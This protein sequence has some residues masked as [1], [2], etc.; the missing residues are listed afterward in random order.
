M[1]PEGSERHLPTP[2]SGAG[3]RVAVLVARFNSSI[4]EEL[5]AGC[6]EGLIE[7]G[8]GQADIHVGY[9]PGAWELPQAAR[10]AAAAA[11]FDVIVALGCVIRGETSH[12]DYVAGE[13]STGLGAVARSIDVPLIFGVLTTDTVE[14]AEARAT[15]TRGNKGRE[16]AVSA[17]AMIDFN[18]EFGSR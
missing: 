12:F 2:R 6:V 7:H 9:V 16:L 4:T 18:A 5:R 17:L 13:A 11:R 14:Q 8:V 3:V 10:T 15:R 1:Q